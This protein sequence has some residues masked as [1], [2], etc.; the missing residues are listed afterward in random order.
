MLLVRLL[1]D[2]SRMPHR[3]PA[4]S[5][6]DTLQGCELRVESKVNHIHNRAVIKCQGLMV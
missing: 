1:A 5:I 4:F 3:L 2:G 6:L